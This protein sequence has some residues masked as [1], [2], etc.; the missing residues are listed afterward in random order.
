MSHPLQH[1]AP[2]SGCRR[3]GHPLTLGMLLSVNPLAIKP[4]VEMQMAAAA[5]AAN[6]KVVSHTQRVQKG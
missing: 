6:A 3:A 2:A 4:A 1:R 5:S